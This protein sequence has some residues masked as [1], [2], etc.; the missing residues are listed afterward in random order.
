MASDEMK[1]TWRQ[2]SK[3]CYMKHK[4]VIQARQ[5]YYRYCQGVSLR[6]ATVDKLNQWLIKQGRQPMVKVT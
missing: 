3:R 4:D 1:E 2:A 6:P 5:A